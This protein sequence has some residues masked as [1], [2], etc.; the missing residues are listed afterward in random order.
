MP[1]RRSV[2]LSGVY[3]DHLY[4]NKG[5]IRYALLIIGMSVSMGGLFY[6]IIPLQADNFRY[7]DEPS[8]PITFDEVITQLCNEPLLRT[9][10]VTEQFFS[11]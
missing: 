7:D 11:D 8:T 5:W 9:F 6:P 10:D 1:Q 2:N 4:L 3:A